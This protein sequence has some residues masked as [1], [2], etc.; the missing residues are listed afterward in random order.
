MYRF[1]GIYTPIVTPFTASGDIDEHGIVSNIVR[2]LA[3]SLT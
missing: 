1:A 3:S 2:Y